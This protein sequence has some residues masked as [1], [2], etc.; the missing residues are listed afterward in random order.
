MS[1]KRPSPAELETHAHWSKPEGRKLQDY[2]CEQRM[3]S[4]TIKA[5]LSEQ[6]PTN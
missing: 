1:K 5:D 2:C 6:A 4:G 3:P